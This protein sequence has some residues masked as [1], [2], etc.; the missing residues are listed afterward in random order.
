VPLT[1]AVPPS[2]SRT[3]FER[4]RTRIPTHPGAGVRARTA[5]CDRDTDRPPAAAS[6]GRRSERSWWVCLAVLTLFA[7]RVAPAQDE[8]A[9]EVAVLFNSA[10]PESRGVAE[11]YAAQR[12][13]PASQLVGLSLP[14]SEGITR[15]DFED[16]LVKPLLG[17]LTSR[18]LLKLRDEIRPAQ[19]DR[20]GRVVQSIVESRV[21]TFA[22]CWGVPLRVLEDASRREPETG[23]LPEP[24]RRNEA[25]VDAELVALPLLLSGQ[26]ITGPL[27]NPAYGATNGAAIG[28]ANGL[29]VVGRLDGPTPALAR[30]LVDRAIEA[31]QKGLLGRAYFDL[32]AAREAGYLAGDRWISNSWALA[33]AYGFDTYLDRQ[34]ASLPTGLPFNHVA[35]YAGWYEP[36]L[37]G[38]FSVAPVEFVPGAI[39]YHLH[40]FSAATLR[41]TNLNWCGPLVHR[42]VTA[43]MGTVAEPF[44]DGT[45][46][47]AACFSR[48]MFFRFTW[49]EAN[50][51][52]QRMLSWQL[53]TVGDPLYR[54][55]PMNAL[56]RYKELSA[57]TDGRSD[58]ALIQLYNR[59]REVGGGLEGVIAELEKEPRLRFSPILQEKLGDFLVEAGEPAKAAKLYRRA[60]SS[61]ASFQQKKRLLWNA[62]ES[63]QA[64][65]E[66]R[67]AYELYRD[68]AEVPHPAADPVQLYER[69]KSLATALGKDRDA[70]RWTAKLEELRPTAPA[71]APAAGPG[72]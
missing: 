54:P 71:G 33:R 60:V 22:I 40:S 6:A 36:H 9:A 69:L 55:F 18:G 47:V 19:E 30:R 63:L 66:D 35:L 67:D 51:A 2:H 23:S 25:A 24:L 72:R 61:P 41:S 44:L 17:E 58:W 38:P 68:L 64:A 49:G 26:P 57:K 37:C 16:R 3:M 29:F 39:A 21:R 5:A 20:P 28:P 11:Y 56:D 43:T 7:G 65:R 8:R 10:L 4:L 70:R 59:R 15:S 62:A 13:I 31:E 14:P 52:A 46:D 1:P 12:G 34:P 27:G 42:G 50:V 45:P 48:L 32:R 53:T